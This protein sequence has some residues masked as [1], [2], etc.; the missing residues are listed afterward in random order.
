MRLK[1]VIHAS[2]YIRGYPMLTLYIAGAE[3]DVDMKKLS[4][5]D[6]AKV[7][8]GMKVKIE[9]PKA[10]VT[11]RE[12]NTALDMAIEAL[13]E[14]PEHSQNTSSKQPDLETLGVKTGET[15][16]DVI[17]RQAAIDLF[18]NDALEWDTK[19]GYIAPHLARRMI[20]ELPSAQPEITDEQA[21]EHL[22]STGWMQNHDR[23]MYESGLREQLADDSG[24]Y[25]SL[26]PCDD[27]ISRQAAIDAIQKLNIP[28][29]MCVFEIISHIEIEIATLPSAQ[30][31][32]RWIPCSERLPE[33]GEDVLVTR[34]YDGR[35]DNN[36]SCR[37]VEVA[38][39]YGEDDDITWSSFSDE[40]K[41]HPKNHYV[42]A[43]MP[44]PKPWKGDTRG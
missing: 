11:Q 30:P 42:V 39:C 43:W 2:T 44:L 20:E 13:K 12:R 27:T 4:Q 32:Q 16:T 22:Q 8:E 26:I 24:S 9:I 36:K 6:A 34:D 3:R 29:D 23:E 17:S 15:C 1:N 25:D 35:K 7:L 31:E 38:S 33:R 18:P 21:I 41:M 19:G 10:A 37:Y 5:E 28:E 40:Y 14:Q